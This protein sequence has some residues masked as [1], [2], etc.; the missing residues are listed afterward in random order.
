MILTTHLVS[1]CDEGAPMTSSDRDRVAVSPLS[2]SAEAITHKVGD[3]YINLNLKILETSG[4][5]QE[6]MAHL[7]LSRPKR[8][9]D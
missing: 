8:K 6:R 4:A 3:D 1:M 2:E 5:M 9:E 7:E